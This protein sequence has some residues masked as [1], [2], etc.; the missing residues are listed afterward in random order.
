MVL[1]QVR[2]RSLFL[3]MSFVLACPA[4]YGADALRQPDCPLPSAYGKTGPLGVTQADS[5]RRN[6]QIDE[7]ECRDSLAKKLGVH[8]RRFELFSSRPEDEDSGL[9]G[10]TDG[11]SI[12][13]ELRW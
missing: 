6:R 4:T 5:Q 2:M 11:R 3:A 1:A 13:L 9:V 7:Q 10:T 12:K 8:D